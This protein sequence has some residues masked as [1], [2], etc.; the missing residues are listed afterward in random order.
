[1][2]KPGWLHVN[3]VQGKVDEEMNIVLVELDVENASTKL[4]IEVEPIK[5]SQE[6]TS[7]SG[8]QNEK[9]L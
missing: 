6:E 8:T 1:M 3:L 5:P 9:H 2:L 7:S 4:S